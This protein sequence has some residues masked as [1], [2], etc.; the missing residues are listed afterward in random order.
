M[1]ALSDDIEIAYDET[2]TGLPVLW[3]HGF[4][5]NRTFWAPQTRALYAHARHIAPDLRGFGG[6]TVAGPWT[7]DRYADDLVALLDLLGIRQAVVAGLSMGGYIALALWRR[8]PTRVRAL[9]L[10]D[11]RASADT[12]EGREKRQAL[13]ALAREQG[14]DAV[15]EQQITGL[16]GKSTRERQP[17]LVEQLRLICASAPVDGIVGAT[18]AMLARPDSTPTLGT[19]TVPTLVVVGEEDAIT[20]PKEARA[21]HDAIRSSRLEVIRGAGHVSS[22]ERPSAFNH[23]MSEFLAALTLE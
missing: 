21:M 16:V 12:A 1:I 18:E 15:A 3:V 2:G 13:I 10:A 11:T 6:S 14:A 20:P 23:V 9:V 7:M 19:I 8:H 5:L 4:P 22:F 17:D